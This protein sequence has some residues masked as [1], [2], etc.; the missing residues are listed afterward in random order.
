LNKLLITSFL[1]AFSLFSLFSP[2]ATEDST[3]FQFY[4]EARN[5]NSNLD[6]E[7]IAIDSIEKLL[8]LKS[9]TENES[10][11]LVYNYQL[12]FL[13][14]TLISDAS[15][16]FQYNPLRTNLINQ[17][18]L[19]DPDNV[20]I[21][22][23]LIRDLLFFPAQVGGNSEK[24]LDQLTILLNQNPDSVLLLLIY[25]EYYFSLNDLTEAQMTYQRIL[26]LQPDNQEA[27]QYIN[28]IELLMG[29]YVI[30]EIRLEESYSENKQFQIITSRYLNQVYSQTLRQEL[31]DQLLA[32]PQIGSVSFIVSK[33]NTQF[34]SINISLSENEFE[35]IALLG[36]A[37]LN[38]N[39][40]NELQFLGFPAFFYMNQNVFGSGN[41]LM[42][43]FAGIFASLD[44]TFSDYPG[45][46]FDL[47]F[48]AD[49][50][51]I[52]FDENVYEKGIASDWEIAS[53][54][55]NFG[56]ALE[57]NFQF[58]LGL[59]FFNS[60]TIK[61][62][63]S[64]SSNFTS[65]SNNFTYS[66][67]L[68]MDFSTADTSFP[69]AFRAPVGIRFGIKQELLY[70]LDYKAWGPEGDLFTHDDNPAYKAEYILGYYHNFNSVLN[71]GLTVNVLHGS[72][73]YQNELWALGQGSNIQPTYRL[74]GYF[75]GEFRTEL[76]AL[77]NFDFTAVLVKDLFAIQLF[78]DLAYISEQESFF[79]GSSV[80]LVVKLD[81][82]LE[83]GLVGSIG[84][85]AQRSFG[86]AWNAQLSLSYVV[87]N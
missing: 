12:A 45:K 72:N 71:L 36:E 74:N 87:I 80:N 55:V 47:R 54:Y 69:S 25:A 46:P 9:L 50:L 16:Y 59:S 19:I 82:S 62:Y 13:Y 26:Q 14:G 44:F 10:E 6:I 51:M 40:D 29:N 37:Q 35:I 52:G 49:G 60:L 56:I 57:K 39:Y 53:P 4:L 81:P 1:I 28:E 61:D 24:G 65:P 27:K 63:Q 76:A 64:E 68:S 3:I 77:A 70:Q 41:T 42:T 66:S 38:P 73:V 83:I 18:L 22:S 20:P 23:L 86:L 7:S 78:H 67:S 79:N 21:Q 58:G 8:K 43:I 5:D 11:I 75:S 48:H 15:S 30:A 2:Y 84:W 34:I 33:L 85:N 17:S 31:E 32:F